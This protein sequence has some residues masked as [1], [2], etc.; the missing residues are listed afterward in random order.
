MLGIQ[1]PL[2]AREI[3][4]DRIR[5]LTLKG[6]NGVGENSKHGEEIK[7]NDPRKAC[8]N[9]KIALPKGSRLVIHNFSFGAE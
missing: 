5:P 6:K 3:N 7:R 2:S 9:P 8:A 1:H 4:H